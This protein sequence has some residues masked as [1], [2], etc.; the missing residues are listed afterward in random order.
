MAKYPQLTTK[1][2]KPNA[3]HPIVHN[4]VT[5]GGSMV[6]KSRRFNAKQQIM[7]HEFDKLEEEGYVRLSSSESSSSVGC[8]HKNKL[9]NSESL[10]VIRT[11]ILQMALNVKKAVKKC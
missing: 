6:T 2:V 9:S 1:G 10:T 8:I 3:E 11:R 7:Q 4:I 5:D